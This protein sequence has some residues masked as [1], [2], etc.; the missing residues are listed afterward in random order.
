MR[1]KGVLA[2]LREVARRFVKGGLHASSS[3]RR[4]IRAYQAIVVPWLW[5]LERRQTRQT[6]PIFQE[7]AVVEIVSEVSESAGFEDFEMSDEQGV[8]SRQT[9]CAQYMETDLAF[10]SR[11]LEEEGGIYH[12]RWRDGPLGQGGQRGLWSGV[13]HAQRGHCRP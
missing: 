7:K 8:R 1:D 6:C 13:G 3:H 12:F 2:T 11:P 4:P 10:V 5:F 9:S